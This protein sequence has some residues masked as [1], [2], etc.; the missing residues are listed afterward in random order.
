[1][2]DLSEELVVDERLVCLETVDETNDVGETEDEDTCVHDRHHVITVQLTAFFKLS[3]NN[4]TW[5][6]VL[7]LWW[8]QEGGQVH[9]TPDN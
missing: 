9:K 6:S 3:P 5:L 8:C 4:V 2:G 1:M 7:S